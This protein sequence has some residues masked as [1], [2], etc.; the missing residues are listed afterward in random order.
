M[1]I[2]NISTTYDA[3]TKCGSYGCIYAYHPSSVDSIEKL[4]D[5]VDKKCDKC[6]SK[7]SIVQIK[8]EIKGLR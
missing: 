3:C 4:A 6:K 2:K 7:L 1:V 5:L 8:V